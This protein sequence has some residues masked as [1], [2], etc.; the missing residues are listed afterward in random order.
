MKVYIGPYKNWIGPYQLADMIPFIS[1]DTSFRIGTWLSKTW[2]N[3]VCEWIDSKRQRKIK[4][5]IDEYDTWNMN[6]TLAHIILPMLKQLKATKH[7]SQFVD[8]EDVPVHMRHGDPEGYDNWVHYKWDWVL[9]EII[10]AFEQ[11]LNDDWEAQ[12][13]HGTPV[14]VDEEVEHEKYGTCYTF[15]QTNP[16]YWVDREGIKAYNDRINNGIRL[17]GKYYRGLWD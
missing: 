11:E 14:Y 4:V 1:E 17:F 6:D 9:N 2:I 16:D 13:T 5:R 7:G 10:W 3:S 8:D 15:K 12:F